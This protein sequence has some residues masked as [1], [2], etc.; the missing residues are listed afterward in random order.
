MAS[1]LEYRRRMREQT[2][3]QI[4]KLKLRLVS[5][6]YD[7]TGDRKMAKFTLPIQGKQVKF[8]M[9]EPHP[10]EPLKYFITCPYTKHKNLSNK[11]RKFPWDRLRDAVWD[12]PV[13]NLSVLED[14]ADETHD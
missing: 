5:I 14:E 10:K 7:L 8:F 3:A 9:I 6:K 13:L 1:E 11:Y 4:E 12:V 2:L